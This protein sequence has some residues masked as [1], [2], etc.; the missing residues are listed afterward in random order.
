MSIKI[1][2]EPLRTVHFII[3]VALR[4]LNMYIEYNSQ[5]LKRRLN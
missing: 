5:L 3:I 2:S 4:Y 1:Q